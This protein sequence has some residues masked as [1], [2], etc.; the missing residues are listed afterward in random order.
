MHPG[1]AL[2]PTCSALCVGLVGLIGVWLQ[3]K[4][5]ASTKGIKAL[6]AEV[7]MRRD[8][9]SINQ[10]LARM[11]VASYESNQKSI[12]SVSTSLAS[13]QHELDNL[14]NTIPKHLEVIQL[15][16]IP[17]NANFRQQKMKIFGFEGMPLKIT[18]CIAITFKRPQCVVRCICR[19]K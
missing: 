12:Q 3:D 4:I 6:S 11:L 5:N 8:S 13:S 17:V 7:Q 18:A 16:M 10:D 19:L 2:E 15:V 14:D 1:T 9:R